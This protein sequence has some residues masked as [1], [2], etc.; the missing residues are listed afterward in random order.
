MPR[1]IKLKAVT[2]LNIKELNQ[3]VSFGENL[4]PSSLLSKNVKIQVYRTII[5][6]VVLYGRKTL[7]FE[8]RMLR[9]IF[10]LKRVKVTGEWRKLHNEG[11]NDLYCSPN[12]FS[13]DQIKK[14]EIG[15][16]CSA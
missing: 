11:L 4:L 14:N 16:A 1:E 15:E 9:R 6:T 12:I 3:K 10:R 5:L 8:N 7:S 13:G 2:I